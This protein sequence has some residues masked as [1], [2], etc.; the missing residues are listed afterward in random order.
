MFTTNL[1]Y[2]LGNREKTGYNIK[3]YTWPKHLNRGLR[4]MKK[5]K[6]EEQIIIEK[7]VIDIYIRIRYNNI[8]KKSFTV[9]IFQILHYCELGKFLYT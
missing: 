6:T 7:T 5:I 3:Q 2:K 4:S 1:K 8:L 9:E